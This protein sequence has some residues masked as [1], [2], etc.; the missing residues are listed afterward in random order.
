MVSNKSDE[1]TDESGDHCEQ[2]A[3][4]ESCTGGLVGFVSARDKLGS[5][6]ACI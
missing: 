6:E 5:V 3:L 4:S 1:I 2:P